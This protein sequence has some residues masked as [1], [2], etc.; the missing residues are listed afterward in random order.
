MG[1]S[2][3]RVGAIVGLLALFA[4][5]GAVFLPLPEA[6]GYTLVFFM[7]PLLALSFLGVHE[8]LVTHRRSVPA[9]FG[10]ALGFAAGVLV[11]LMLVIQGA[12]NILRERG[13]TEDE[14]SVAQDASETVWRAVNRVQF[15]ID[16]SWDIFICLAGILI[17]IAMLSHPRF[18][19]IFGWSGRPLVALWYAVVFAQMLMPGDWSSEALSSVATVDSTVD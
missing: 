15:S 9:Y 19:K 18:G 14:S 10:C 1:T 2:L 3:I 12:N 8:A 5:F 4:Y 6:I 17:G 13:L 11:N 16:V 7:G